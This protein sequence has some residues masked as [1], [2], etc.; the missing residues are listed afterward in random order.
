MKLYNLE[1]NLADDNC[2]QLTKELQNTAISDNQLYNYYFTND[3]KCNILDDFLFDNNMVIKDGYGIANS[4][5]IDTDS[6][7]R[8]N[9]KL[10]HDREKIQ[11]CTRWD[12]G[13]PNLNKGGLIPNIESKLKNADDTS[14]IRN[15]DRIVEHNYNRFT[16]LVGCLAA[17]IQNPDY[18][19]TPKEWV[20]GGSM[21]RNDVRTNAYLEK[22]GFENNGKNWVR[23]D[24]K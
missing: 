6:E 17:T 3:C 22:C 16:P 8:Y 15:C 11:L 12:L 9:S 21:T 2:A 4:C 1:N 10:T 24:I 13:G 5:T 19:I 18:I 23:K 20:R 14:D 7:L